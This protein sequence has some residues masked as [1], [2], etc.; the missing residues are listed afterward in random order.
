MSHYV[1]RLSA[2]A[3][4]FPTYFTTSPN[5][6]PFVP[7]P[8]EDISA[9]ERQTLPVYLRFRLYLR[10]LLLAIT[11]L[12][13]Y[14]GLVASFNVYFAFGVALLAVIG[15][16]YRAAWKAS[17]QWQLSPPQ[18]RAEVHER[19]DFE[20]TMALRNTGP[21]AMHGMSLYLE[22][23]GSTQRA[24]YH[25]VKFL[26][27]LAS[28]TVRVLSPRGSRTETSSVPSSKLPMPLSGLS[29]KVT[30]AEARGGRNLTK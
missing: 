28:A 16:A 10:A 13:L 21:R 15:L 6:A 19:Q 22:F 18:H 5:G 27:P 9:L 23:Q 25:F 1:A 26:P 4:R 20:V 30:V 29:L 7:Q 17:G 14:A 8:W 24:H 11:C 12:L 3:A 2:Y